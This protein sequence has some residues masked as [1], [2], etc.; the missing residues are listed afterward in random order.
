[1]VYITYNNDVRNIGYR[2]RYYSLQYLAIIYNGHYL[3]GIFSGKTE[4]IAAGCDN[5]WVM[6]LGSS[7]VLFAYSFLLLLGQFDNIYK[8]EQDSLYFF[9]LGGGFK[10]IYLRERNFTL[11]LVVSEIFLKD[12]PLH[13]IFF[14]RAWNIYLSDQ[15]SLLLI[16]YA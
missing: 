5:F 8:V 14:V 16:C 15:C 1:M 2:W 11:W 13:F 6:F 12:P 7:S 9:F 3:S 10:G 4:K